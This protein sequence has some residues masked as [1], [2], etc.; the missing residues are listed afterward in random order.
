[1]SKRSPAILLDDIHSSLS[2]I[3]RYTDGLDEG[4][5]LLDEK[6]SMQWSGISGSSERL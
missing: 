3:L 1:M 4:Q 5:F 6:K 2:K